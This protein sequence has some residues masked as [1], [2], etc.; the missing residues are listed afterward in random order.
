MIFRAALPLLALVPLLAVGGRKWI[1]SDPRATAPARILMY[2]GIPGTSAG[3]FERQMRYLGASF[4][5]VSLASL[6]PPLEPRPGRMRIAL[7]FDDGLRNNVTVAYPILSRLRLPA[8]FFVCPQLIDR[9]LWLWNQQARQRLKRLDGEAR[10]KLALGVGCPSAEVEPFIDWMKS[11]AASLRPT[12]E[13]AVRRATPEFRP[14]SA[15]R[16]AFDIARWEDLRMLAPELITIGSHTLTHPILTTLAGAELETEIGGS[17]L[18][19]EDKL[20]RPVEL[21]AYPNGSQNPQVYGCARRHYRAAVLA[22]PDRVS[23]NP[24]P[25]LMPRDCAPEGVLRLA[26]NLLREMRGQ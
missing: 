18:V 5:V 10:A 7:T 19:L 2:H 21:F 20:Q 9:G 11:L 24:D 14:T 16:E 1:G 25:H 22:S 12:V 15:E 8:T 3:A 4:D 13:A 26:R 23:P 17:R 6:V